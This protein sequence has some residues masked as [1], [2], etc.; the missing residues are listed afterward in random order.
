M[1]YFAVKLYCTAGSWTPGEYRVSGDLLEV[2]KAATFGGQ[3]PAVHPFQPPGCGS[4]RVQDD[5]QA[6]V[7]HDCT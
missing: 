3:G 1:S 5:V 2:S 7:R 4:L 6:D